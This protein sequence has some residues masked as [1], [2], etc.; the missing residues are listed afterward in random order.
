MLDV[1]RTRA[2]AIGRSRCAGGGCPAAHR[3]AGHGFWESIRSSSALEEFEAY[4]ELF[5][6]GTFRTLAEINNPPHLTGA[7]SALLQGTSIT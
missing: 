4:L 7:S 2:A 1:D 6:E 3:G 5:P